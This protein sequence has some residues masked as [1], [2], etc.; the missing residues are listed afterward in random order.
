MNDSRYDVT[1]LEAAHQGDLDAISALLTLAHPDIRR[2]A[3]LIFKAADVNDV[4]PQARWFTV[5][6][7]K[8]RRIVRLLGLHG[9][10]THEVGKDEFLLLMPAEELRHDLAR[11]IQAL[12]AHYRVIILLHDIEARPIGEVAAVLQQVTEVVKGELLR[13]RL[14]L[15]EYLR[16]C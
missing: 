9:G 13:A 6:A 16:N 5:L 3:Y 7:R 15:C 10:E 4:E 8:C 1:M 2:Y 12:P 14:T 11:A